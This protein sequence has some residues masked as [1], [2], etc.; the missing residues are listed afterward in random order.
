MTTVLLTVAVMLS[1]SLATALVVDSD[2]REAVT[3]TLW[4]MIVGP[5][6]LSWMG[7]VV[8]LR[9]LP[10]PIRPRRIRGRALSPKTLQR[11]ADRAQHDGWMVSSRYASIVVIRRKKV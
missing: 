9:L 8:L 6:L 3:T 5:I 1:L 4:A 7:A 2:V 11:V 10:A